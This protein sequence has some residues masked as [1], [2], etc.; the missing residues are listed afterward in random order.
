MAVSVACFKPSAPIMR[1]YIHLMGST[2]ASPSGAADT[3]PICCSLPLPAA[4]GAVG[5]GAVRRLW[6]QADVAMAFAAG[7]VIRLDDEQARV[8]ALRAG[9][10]LQADA[11]ITGRLAQPV[12]KQSIEFVIARQLV[13]RREGVHVRE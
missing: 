8:L 2:P 11:G 7:R 12:A 1:T 4:R 10:G 9:V 13:A 5:V 3:A 6:N